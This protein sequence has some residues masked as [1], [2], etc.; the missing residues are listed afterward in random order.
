MDHPAAPA[1]VLAARLI[2]RPQGARHPAR[3]R[4]SAHEYALSESRV[5]KTFDPFR[6]P[7][8]NQGHER[9][10]GFSPRFLVQAK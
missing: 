9:L 10:E 2:P 5:R 7:V 6:R 8:Y 4:S 1:S 3:T